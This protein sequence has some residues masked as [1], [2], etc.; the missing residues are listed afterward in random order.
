MRNSRNQ[1]RPDKSSVKRL[2]K[3]LALRQRLFSLLTIRRSAIRLRSFGKT[4]LMV[5]PAAVL[6]YLGV[7]YMLDKA[8]G[9][10]VERIVFKSRH[11]ILN[12]ERALHILGLQGSVNMA[13]LDV[14]SLR[15]RLESTP[16]IRSAIIQAELPS[17]LIIEVEER[18]PIARVE[19][20]HGARTGDRTHFFVDPEGVLFPVNEE[21]HS[22]FLGVPTWYL[23]PEDATELHEGMQLAPERVRPIAR[24]VAAANNYTPEEIPPIVEI[25]RPKDW[26]ICLILDNGAEITMEQRN[27]REQMERLAL[28]LDHARAT[29]RRLISANVIPS[30]NPVAVFED[31]DSERKTKN[32]SSQ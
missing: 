28:I 11:G 26:K 12:K 31:S 27:I 4:L 2:E 5:L 21:L 16:G 20:E 7:Q 14:E 32:S 13:T 17:S 22:Q 6:L 19:W 10:S 25:F 15:N 18:I 30:L 23:R 24:I 29:H 3:M 8:Y 9:L 1:F